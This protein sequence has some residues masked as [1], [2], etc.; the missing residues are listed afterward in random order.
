MV[1]CILLLMQ[2][3]Q[4]IS[5]FVTM[6]IIV[7]GCATS[8]NNQLVGP[9]DGIVVGQA[10]SIRHIVPA[11]D[12]ENAAK[13][14][15][16]KIKERAKE[17][18]ELASNNNPTLKRLIEIAKKL[19]PHTV[20]WNPDSSSWNWEVILIKSDSLNAFCFPGGKI[21]FFS[22]IIEKL[23]LTDDE[24]AM[25]MGHEMAHALREHAR[26]RIAKA[27]LT[28]LG[29]DLLSSVIGL[30][31]SERKLMGFGRQLVSLKFSRIDETDADL[32]GL[33]IAARGG[34]NPSAGITLWKKMQNA[35]KNSPPEWLSTHPSGDNRINEIS[36]NLPKVIPLFKK[37]IK[38]AN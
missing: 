12:L 23:E 38:S 9:G 7:T 19:E 15:Y 8:P 31:Q 3:N 1:G 36:K 17:K 13:K 25:I 29:V 26:S 4:K 20:A 37:S 24:I 22:G 28:D 32:V 10:S 16:E 5:F 30:N 35:N 14:E 11:K 2:V 6:A 34:F 18:K 27:Q 21:A 33:D